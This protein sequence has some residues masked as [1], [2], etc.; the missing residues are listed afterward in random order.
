MSD[1]NRI[2]GKQLDDIS[3]YNGA[4]VDSAGSDMSDIDGYGLHF[5]STV[6]I[7][8]D[9]STVDIDNTASR[10]NA[11]QGVT[12]SDWQSGDEL[13][14]NVS[15]T[16]TFTN[17]IDSI[18]IHYS[19]DS[20]TSWTQIHN[21]TSG[22]SDTDS[23][24]DVDYGET[25]RIRIDIQASGE[26]AEGDATVTLTGGSFTK[27]TGTVTAVSPTEFSLSLAP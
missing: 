12:I 11:Y 3:A 23:I 16:A 1:I 4:T 21:Y 24:T 25:L 6:T 2:N 22:G 14:I 26:D 9:G 5:E 20:T 18:D 19:I 15:H 10:H 13:T 17:N 8:F 7:K 27:G